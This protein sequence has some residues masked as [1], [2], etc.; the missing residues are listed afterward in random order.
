[1]IAFCAECGAELKVSPS[2]VKTYTNVYCNRVCKGMH[3]K[4][5]KTAEERTAFYAAKLKDKWRNDPEYRAKKR[6]WDKRSRINQMKKPDFA[7]RHRIAARKWLKKRYHSD[8]EFRARHAEHNRRYRLR[9][10]A[11]A[12]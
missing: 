2:R 10:Q 5:W 7:E 11:L 12:K 4:K 6:V 9:K 8:A 1:M 3:Q